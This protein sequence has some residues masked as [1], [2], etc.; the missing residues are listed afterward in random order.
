MKWDGKRKKMYVYHMRDQW[1]FT[2]IIHG[3]GLSSDECKPL[4]YLVVSIPQAVLSRNKGRG[5]HRNKVWTESRAKL[6]GLTWS[7]W[8]NPARQ[9][10]WK[11][12]VEYE[13]HENIDVEV[14]KYE[15]Y[16]IDKLS[17]DKNTWHKCAF[18]SEIKIIYDI[19][20]PNGMSHILVNKVNNIFGL[21]FLHDGLNPYKLTKN[22]NSHYYSIL[23]GC[24]NTLNR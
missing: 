18:E 20:R 19:N 2:C 10:K 1:K 24:M 6:Y 7:W 3:P 15:L 23:H 4:N 17:L 12:S 13:I 9:W 5:F 8:D 11:L 14:N 21:N 16:K 22:I